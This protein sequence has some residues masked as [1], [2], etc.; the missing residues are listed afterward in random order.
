[1]DPTT[2]DAQPSNPPSETEP[3]QAHTTDNSR[4]VPPRFA[5]SYQANQAV[6]QNLVNETK[7][8]ISALIQ[9]IAE[10]AQSD[11]TT[12]DFYSGFLTRT[13]SALASVGGA[14]WTLKEEGNLSLTYHI[15][16][17]SSGLSDEPEKQVTHNRLLSRLAES[18]EPTLV[19]PQSS[20]AETDQPGNPTDFLLVICPLK[21][22]QQV[23]GLVEVFQRAGTGPT[24]QRGYLRFLMQMCDIASDFLKNRRI[25]DFQDQQQLWS[26]LEGFIHATHRGLNPQQTAFSIANEG[27]RIIGCNRAS[28][29]I[30]KNGHSEIK[31]VSGLDSI[32]RRA[33]QV[34][35]LNNLVKAA[36]RTGEPL[37]YFGSDHDL[38]PQIESKFARIS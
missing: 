15:N 18:G 3:N 25:R 29:A 14:V 8:Q 30:I 34:K 31:S 22:D 33:S 36:M 21:I 2:T 37:W 27:K 5:Q 28:I 23:V 9:E 16:L 13:T 19:A 35:L 24:T 7:K 6:D 38:P 26:Q 1:M 10:L 12:E 17:A 20:G 4:S 11:V 32:E